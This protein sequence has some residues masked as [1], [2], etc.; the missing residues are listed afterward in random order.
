MLPLGLMASE[1]C[2]FRGLG[3]RSVVCWFSKEFSRRKKVNYWCFGMLILRLSQ[4]LLKNIPS[5][6]SHY[7]HF[8]DWTGL[9]KNL[10]YNP[11]FQMLVWGNHEI[12]YNFHGFV[13]AGLVWTCMPTSLRYPRFAPVAQAWLHF[14][15]GIPSS[16]LA[17]QW[18]SAAGWAIA[19]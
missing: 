19:Y 8:P 12:M 14:C 2:P 11:Q 10:N 4:H 5:C 9:R 6:E 18:Y 16:R 7:Y 13:S 3:P 17:T 1:L 15:I